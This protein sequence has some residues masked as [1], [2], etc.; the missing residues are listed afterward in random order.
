MIETR[1]VET[2]VHG[3]YLL[4]SGPAERLL[5]GFH[6][7][8]ENAEM[9]LLKLEEIPGMGEWTVAAVQALH[10]FYLRST[11]AV[12]AS[13]MTRVD[14]EHTIADNIA[15]VRR[16]V[17]E[18]PRPRT[19]V[20]E[21]FSQGAAMA[22]RAAV[23]IPCAG[24]VVLGGNIPPEIDDLSKLPRLLVG[25]GDRDEWYTP[26]KFE[27]DKKFLSSKADLVTCFFDGGHEWSDAFRAAAG[28]FL[29]HLAAQ[30]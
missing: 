11:Q 7:Y 15:Y 3:R 1:L 26:D 30:P 28:K 18:L 21:G 16:V 2:S 9:H 17:A 25:R 19:L 20:F 12:V 24:L 13:W 22:Y 27:R 23:S 8:A 10:P 4:R 14:R 29:A 6:G 5:V